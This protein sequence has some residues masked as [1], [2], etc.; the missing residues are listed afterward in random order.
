M[1]IVGHLSKDMLRYYLKIRTERLASRLP[2]AK[3]A[4][5]ANGLVDKFA[6]V[7]LRRGLAPLI[8][9]ADGKW[10]IFETADEIARSYAK[11]ALRDALKIIE[12]LESSASA[13]SA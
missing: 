6:A 3:S 13:E 10:V 8:M 7:R 5:T 9:D 4:A 2:G 1:D 11:K 12:D